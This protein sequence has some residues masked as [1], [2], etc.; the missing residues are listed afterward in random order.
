MTS[1]AILINTRDFDSNFNSPVQHNSFC[2][3]ASSPFKI[4]PEMYFGI[5]SDDISK[6]IN[7]WNSKIRYSRKSCLRDDCASKPVFK[8]SPMI[9]E[10]ANNIPEFN[11]VLT[12]TYSEISFLLDKDDIDYQINVDVE[13]DKEFPE[14]KETVVSIKI[15]NVNEDEILQIWETIENQIQSRI[16]HMGNETIKEKYKNLILIVNNF[17]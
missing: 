11:T 1:D 4:K 5:K 6:K 14:W 12:T 16:D 2:I 9:R 15:A 7:D 8:I 3:N 17:E 10:M 13:E